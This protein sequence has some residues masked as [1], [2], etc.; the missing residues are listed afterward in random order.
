MTRCDMME[1]TMSAF[2]DKSAVA[3]SP[4]SGQSNS[5][6]A[7]LSADDQR[8]RRLREAWH[9]TVGAWA[10]DDKGTAGLVQRL[11]AFG[12]LSS[13]EARRVLADAKK[14]AEDN[15]A[16]LDRRVDESLQRA[17][18]FFTREQKEM[19][20][21]EDRLASLEERLKALDA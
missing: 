11:V 7:S 8:G 6:G 10:T 16:E 15:K 2:D 21:L 12:T 17:A 20:K 4:V 14:R 19:K 5:V 9:K 13:E 1:T 3:S 18:S